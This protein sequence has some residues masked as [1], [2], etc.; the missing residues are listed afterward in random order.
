MTSAGT[1]IG[2][3][4]APT[5]N[6]QR[7][8][9]RQSLLVLVAPDRAQPGLPLAARHWDVT[10]VEADPGD[11]F[12]AP[13]EFDTI[14]I[15]GAARDPQWFETLVRRFVPTL[16]T[17]GHV[18]VML[19]GW[20]GTADG[21]EPEPPTLTGLSWVGL[22]RLDGRPCAVLQHTSGPAERLDP[23]GLQL[24][25]ANST[26]R[27]AAA[28]GGGWPLGSDPGIEL[29]RQTESRR[30]SEQALLRHLESA[31][32]LLDD[33]R[34]RHRGTALVKTLLSRWRLGRASV[35]AFSPALRFV[36]RVRVEVRRAMDPGG[37]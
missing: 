24:A 29:A 31:G 26:C 8:N 6:W 3:R 10:V 33:E 11:P 5:G 4:T 25:T 9:E 32:R 21:L 15:D 34:R 12:E 30:R 16:R 35:R 28:D 36:R 18:V 2:G 27:L 19:P 13:G 23:A 37:R 14:V 17:G 20:S 22:D 7:G 1:A